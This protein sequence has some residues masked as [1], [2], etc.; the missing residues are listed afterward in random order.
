MRRKI[1]QQIFAI[2][3]LYWGAAALSAGGDQQ[4]SDQEPLDVETILQETPSAEDYVETGRCL[5]RND[6]QHVEV[7]DDRH[8]L[9]E[10]R[11]GVWLNRL[12]SRCAIR[13]DAILVF[14]LRSNR[15]CTSDRVT[16]RTRGSYSMIQGSCVLGDFQEIDPQQ[17]LALKE[18]LKLAK[19]S[20]RRQSKPPESE[21]NQ[22][23]ED[24]S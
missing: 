12:H 24:P 17:A 14:E 13:K 9:F 6:Y 20:Q 4:S 8:I 3:A 16:G 2:V 15:T 18:S 7:L 19:K 23:T 10:G 22:Q 5:H 21:A 11:R 1:I